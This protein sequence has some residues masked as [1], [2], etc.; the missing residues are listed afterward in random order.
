MIETTTSSSMMVKPFRLVSVTASLPRGAPGRW[1]GSG[2]VGQ[3]NEADHAVSS[4][5]GLH[6]HATG[7]LD[8]HRTAP[9]GAGKRPG[10]ESN[11]R[12]AVQKHE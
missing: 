7:L 2:D 9:P 6:P 4:G 12:P 8:T 11:L 10:Q 5:W 3:D 1:V